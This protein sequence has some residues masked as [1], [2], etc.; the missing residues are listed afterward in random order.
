MTYYNVKIDIHMEE[1]LNDNTLLSIAM[2][3][4]FVGL[5][6]LFLIMLFY[7]MPE[8]SLS[9]AQDLEDSDKIKLSGYVEKISYSKN[10]ETT[11]IKL[12]DECYFDIVSFD[13]VK[14]GNNTHITVEGTINSKDDKKSLIADKITIK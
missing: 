7:D 1:K 9:E 6:S 4:A 12:R 11:F 2:A 8:K 10:N 14:I 3:C 13:N 5:L